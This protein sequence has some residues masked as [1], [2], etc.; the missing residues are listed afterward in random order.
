M[1]ESTKHVIGGGM[2]AFVKKTFLP[3]FLSPL[4]DILVN[5]T[6][7]RK[8]YQ[9]SAAGAALHKTLHVADLHCD[10]L[11]SHRDLAQRSRRGHVD[12]PR[13]E[14]GN[15]ALQVFAIVT[16][17]PVREG[18]TWL[19]TDLDA[20]TFKLIMQRWPEPAWHSPFER[21]MH[22]A[23]RLHAVEA[24]ADGRFRIIRSAMALEHF[25]EERRHK[26]F[27]T[28]GIL[29]VEGLH[30][31]EGDIAHLDVLY[32]AGVRIA[33][34]VHLAGNE[35]GGA[36]HGRNR[37]GITPFGEQVARRMEEKRVLI[38]LA[39]ASPTL[40]DDVL[41]MT[42]QPVIVSHTGLKSVC[43]NE[44][45]LSDAHLKRIAEKGGV[46]G[47][48]F[49]PW[50]SGGKDLASFIRS[51]RRGVELVGAEHIALGSDFDGAVT[52]PFDASGVA[53]VTDAL[54]REGLPR[55]DIANIMGENVLRLLRR[56]LPEKDAR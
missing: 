35:L 34:L 31:L 15:V 50:A 37:G 47:I 17:A 1:Q 43:D 16:H 3:F 2:P 55:A 53:L 9:I 52:T 46:V 48:G 54:A 25:L 4:F 23:Q 11:F 26:P 12:L 10:A 22:A 40:I 28:S 21:A 27:L 51:I 30:C 39:H 6:R 36:A 41:N 42:T 18:V 44:R 8:P 32:D 49:F 14:A 19:P 20:L 5:R 38:D 13:L 29:A 7:L 24:H 56:A 45:N 33:G